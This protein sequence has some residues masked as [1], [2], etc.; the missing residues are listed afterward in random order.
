MKKLVLLIALFLATS[1]GFANTNSVVSNDHKSVS[2]KSEIVLTQL[3]DY[4]GIYG[5]DTNDIIEVQDKIHVTIKVSVDH[6][7]H[8]TVTVTITF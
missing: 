8:V 5:V 3:N 2:E 7:G 4:D 1:F 6:N